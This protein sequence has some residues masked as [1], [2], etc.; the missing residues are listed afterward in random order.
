MIDRVEHHP[1]GWRF[2]RRTIQRAGAPVTIWWR[3]RGDSTEGTAVASDRDAT[4]GARTFRLQAAR[5]G[6]CQLR[7][8]H[9]QDAHAAEVGAAVVFEGTPC[10]R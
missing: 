3:Y 1:D 7:V 2:V 8:M 9:S 10:Q 5:C 4:A 6:W